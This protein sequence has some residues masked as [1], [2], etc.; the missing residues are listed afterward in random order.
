M[1]SKAVYLSGPITGLE[2][3]EARYGWRQHV[4][5]TLAGTGITML[6]PMRHEGH[7]A[8][9]TGAMT[10]EALNE[11]QERTNHFFSHSKMIVAKDLLDIDMSSIVLVYVLGAQAISKGTIAE[12]GYAYAKGKTIITVMENKGNMNDGPFLREMSDAV[13]DNLDDAIVAIKSLLSEGV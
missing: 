11:F 12:V 10:E 1:L 5:D 6:S 4:A 2:Y 7:L 13:L 8:E 9:M 3:G